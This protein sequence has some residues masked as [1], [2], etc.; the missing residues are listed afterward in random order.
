MGYGAPLKNQN[1]GYAAQ[2]KK[3]LMKMPGDFK[4]M[5]KGSWMSKH[6][7]S[8]LAMG[9]GSG[10]YMNDMAPKMESPAELT[11]EGKKKIMASDANPAFKAAIA[12]ESPTKMHGGPLHKHEKGHNDGLKKGSEL[13]EAE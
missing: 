11:A 3:D 1:K 5:S 12:K 9:K 2:E 8:P 13:T 10:M 6:I 7:S 4:Q